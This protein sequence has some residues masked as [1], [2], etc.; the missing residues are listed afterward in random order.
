MAMD[1][2]ALLQ[3]LE[4]LERQVSVLAE[5]RDV[6]QVKQI[7]DLGPAVAQ[8]GHEMPAQL[9]GITSK[10]TISGIKDYTVQ[11][12]AFIYDPRSIKKDAFDRANHTGD[13]PIANV[14]G[15]VKKAGDTMTGPLVLPADPTTNLQAAT[16]AYVDTK[17]ASGGIAEAP[18]D[19]FTYGRRSSGWVSLEASFVAKT[20]PTGASVQ[21]AGT[22]A[23][24]PAGNTAGHLR[25]NSDLSMFE[26]NNGTAWA[27]IGG[28]NVSVG[29]S[30]PSSP[31][32][33][34]L[35]WKSDAGLLMVYYNDG[36]TSQ[37]VVSTPSQDLAGLDTRYTKKTG[38]TMSGN[39]T[40]SA[41]GITITS[42]GINIQAGG[43]TIPAGNISMPAGL[44]QVTY[45]GA[46]TYSISGTNTN[47]VSGAGG[48][49][50]QV[51]SCYGICGFN[52]AGTNY[53]F[54]G[55]HGLY[56]NGNI[57]GANIIA[58]S[59]IQITG[60]ISWTNISNYLMGYNSGANISTGTGQFDLLFSGGSK[61]IWTASYYAPTAD[62]SLYCGVSSQRWYQVY[63]VTGTIQTSDERDKQ[64]I[65]P[66]DDA[67]KRVAV[68]L[69]GLLVMYRWKDQVVK[70][71]DGTARMYAGIIAQQVEQA[72]VDE[73]LD[74]NGYAM[75]QRDDLT[76]WVP[77]V[78]D[79][80]G[81]IVEEAHEELTGEYRYSVDYSQVLAF[82]IG[83]M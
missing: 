55:S 59:G 67:E 56:C 22:T 58:A 51:G 54:Y 52:S 75:W 50:G 15:A 14:P 53:S 33:G 65:R 23:Q 11:A 71:G 49:I 76:R 26:G 12:N 66:M 9:S 4:A 30:P 70:S 40:V 29:T 43:L 21:P 35:W 39:L 8:G 27:G 18:T 13:V 62:N 37:W 2:D 16:K 80:E 17:T 46:A 60:A 47:N 63:A 68:A 78:I 42:G 6:T 3:R 19:G 5:P 31:Q 79:E 44:I 34:Q 57:Q 20:A 81:N 28:G 7:K 82:I 48:V 72:F 73:G 83:G 36:N 45:G 32:P 74:P 77:A 24:R 69:K 10:V 64:D 25:Y 61:F 38:D 1:T 41:G